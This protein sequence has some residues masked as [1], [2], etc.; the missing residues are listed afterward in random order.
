MF[1]EKIFLQELQDEIS[2]NRITLPTLPEVALR[3]R[4]AAESESST[5]REIAEIVSTDAAVSARLLQVANSALYRG[6]SSI[7]S[8][9]V[10]VT[11][12]GV[13]MVRSLVVSLAMKGLFQPTSD[14]VDRRFRAI[15][16]HSV[17]VAAISR[18]LARLQPQ[19][20]AEQAMLAGL[21]HNIGALPILVHAQSN[22]EYMHNEE[23]LD[24]LL[25][26]LSPIVGKQILE[27]WDFSPDLVA[28][29][30]HNNDF[31]YCGGSQPDY[32]DLVIV[33][34]LQSM[35]EGTE[36][37]NTPNWEEI[38]SFEKLGLATEVEVIEMEGAE[39]EMAG[40]KEMFLS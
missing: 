10:A 23:T 33:A 21:I 2:S 4:D 22:D 11:R 31:S 13:R 37:D 18:V 7:D 14:A 38:P 40:V 35:G 34:R 5:A 25:D 26:R 8:V 30:E 17:E 28:V 29:T 20:N 9:Q 36:L 6:S 24:L 39:D 15:W 12:L 3:V 1:D 27:A 32:V 19:L 16:E